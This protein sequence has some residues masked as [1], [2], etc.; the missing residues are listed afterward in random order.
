MAP[1]PQSGRTPTMPGRVVRW[2]YHSAVQVAR[3]LNALAGDHHARRALPS[4]QP[5]GPA[6]GSP[7]GSSSTSMPW[8]SA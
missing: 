8:R 2:R 3:A 4:V 1:D 5:D 6:W 7:P